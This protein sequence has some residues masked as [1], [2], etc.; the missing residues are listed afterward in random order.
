MSKII[1]ILAVAVLSGC[2]EVASLGKNTGDP[3]CPFGKAK[4]GLCLPTLPPPDTVVYPPPPPPDTVVHPPPPPPDT[5]VLPPPSSPPTGAAFIIGPQVPL[6]QSPWSFF[7]S[8][9]VAKAKT[10]RDAALAAFAGNDG[11]VAYNAVYYDL[12]LSLYVLN[13][14]TGDP[15]HLQY[16]QDVAAGWW[17]LMPKTVAWASEPY[18][19]APRNASFGGLLLYAMSGGGTQALAF[20][21]G[22]STRQL[23]LWQWLTGYAREHY[24]IWLG[25]RLANQN[26]HFGV[27]DGAYTL[28]AVAW[29]AQVHP[30]ATV[31]AE[32]RDKAL[33]AARDYYARLQRAD[34]G[35]YWD[36]DD[37]NGHT[38]A[39]PFMVGMLME[40]LTAV[41][42]LTGDPATANAIVRGCDWMW[43]LGYEQQATTNL[44]NV[45][46]RA[47]KYFV[48]NDGRV[49]TRTSA[50][51]YGMP[52]GGIR[53]ARQLNSTTI[54]AFGYAFKLTGDVK[55][56][57]QGDEIFAASYGKG[58]GPDADAYWALADYQ[59][60][61]YNQSYRS[62]ARYLAWRAGE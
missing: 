44:P 35:W 33:R 41:H 14:R 26:L 50:A 59:A 54:H 3:L 29:L 25:P 37:G 21:D 10:H 8:N 22:N 4:K 49:L 38:T 1:L 34:G 56:R 45:R 27:R 53:D 5:V 47:M 48:Y 46:W 20:K 60:K 17:E 16:A 9:M 32:M 52:D 13:A 40:A 31:R 6:G 61:E 7:D 12:A 24:G 43:T 39:Q 58:Q 30:D 15:T 2:M 18:G 62:G 42:Q 19:V 23:T 51:Q 36:I 11:N 57:T 28:Q 55:Y